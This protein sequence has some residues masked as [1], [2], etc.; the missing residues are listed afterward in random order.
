MFSTKG[1][2]PLSTSCQTDS[3]KAQEIQSN[4]DTHKATKGG[5]NQATGLSPSSQGQKRKPGYGDLED[6]PVLYSLD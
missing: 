2:L 5:A 4:S 3:D 1:R 6:A